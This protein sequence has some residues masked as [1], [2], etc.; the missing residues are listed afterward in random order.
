MEQFLVSGF[1]FQFCF[2]ILSDPAG[3]LRETAGESKDPYR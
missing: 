2:V 1:W 3:S